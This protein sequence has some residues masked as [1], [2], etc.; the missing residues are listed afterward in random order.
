M[1][2]YE[3]VKDKV[4][5]HALAVESGEI[6][7]DFTNHFLSHFGFHE[8]DNTRE[9]MVNLEIHKDNFKK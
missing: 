5:K 6:K 8:N 1:K 2:K 9:E 3:T 4:R 7:D